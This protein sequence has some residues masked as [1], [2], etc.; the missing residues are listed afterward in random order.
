MI[1]SIVKTQLYWLQGFCLDTHM[2]KVI[3]VCEWQNLF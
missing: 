2:P 3:S 1:G